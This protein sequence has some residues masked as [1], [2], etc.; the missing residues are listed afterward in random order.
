LAGGEGKCRSGKRPPVRRFR[1]SSLQGTSGKIMKSRARPL[2]KEFRLAA[3][4]CSWPP[5]D[6]RTRN[7]RE[8]ASAGIDWPRFLR[9]VRR[10]RIEGLAAAALRQAEV[11]LPK[12]EADALAGEASNIVRQNL[13]QAAESQRL[14]RLFQNAGV[15]MLFVKGLP[16]SMLAY[17]NIAQKK[18]WDVDLVVR[19]EDVPGAA[20][21]LREAGY[22][23]LLPP[24]GYDDERVRIWLETSKESLWRHPQRRVSV[25]LHSRL[26]DN[27]LLVPDIDACSPSV[28]VEVAPGIRLPTLEEER[29]FSYICV[30]G[31][32]HGW[33]RLKWLADVAALLSARDSAAV[34]RLYRRS[35]ELG[36][37][38]CSAQALLLCAD[39]FG[40]ALPQKLEQE[41]RSD[42]KTRWLVRVAFRV[43]AG[44][45]GETELDETLLGTVP[46]LLSHFF[47]DRGLS[48]KRKEMSLKIGNAA[49][50][51]AAPLHPMLSFLQ[52]VMAIPVWLL[53]RSRMRQAR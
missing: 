14:L 33:S 19:P 4:C 16:L 2:P 6:T 53:R 20:G 44:P 48:F 15:R 47:L 12:P 45:R 42:L 28:E 9:I 30:H 29:L 36:S 3:E 17:G 23:R 41:L 13:V 1:W 11:V 43:M 31:A 7:I 37:G 35:L 27:P 51:T 52:P 50:R 24:P 5:S 40:T 39:L 18:A 46:T 26:Q 34:E 38:R 22:E 49:D 21:I 25:E 32:T 10:H 8:L